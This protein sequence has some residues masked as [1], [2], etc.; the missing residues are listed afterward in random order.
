MNKLVDVEQLSLL[1]VDHFVARLEGIYE[2]RKHGDFAI[3]IA[4]DNR[5]YFLTQSGRSFPYAPT[6]DWRQCGPIIDHNQISIEKVETGWRAHYRQTAVTTGPT[7][8]IA[9]MRTRV[10]MKFPE[11]V[12]VGNS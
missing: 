8:M 7:A 1:Q 6:V 3:H 5:V 10:K 2:M 4:D 12:E 11:G 9:A